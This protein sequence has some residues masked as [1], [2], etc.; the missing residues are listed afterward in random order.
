[1]TSSHATP[2]ERF[3]ARD[4]L[5]HLSSIAPKSSGVNGWCGKVIVKPF[6]ITGPM[7]T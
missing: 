2:G 7:V 3:V 6:S 1:L 5:A 4:D